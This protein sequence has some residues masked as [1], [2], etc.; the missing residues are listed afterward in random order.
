ME[1]TEFY[2]RLLGLEK[3]WDVSEVKLDVGGG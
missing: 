3:P 1:Q 2:E